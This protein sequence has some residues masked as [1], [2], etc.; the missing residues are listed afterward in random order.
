MVARTNVELS[1]TQRDVLNR[2]MT[3]LAANQPLTVAA[4]A[5]NA[6]SIE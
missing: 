3:G 1:A 4:L 6:I 5:L 2:G